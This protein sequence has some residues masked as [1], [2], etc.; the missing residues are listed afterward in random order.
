MK[1]SIRIGLAGAGTVGGGVIKI[2]AQ[3]MSF[4]RN[5]LQLPLELKKIATLEPSRLKNFPVGTAEIVGDG[6]EVASDPEI[7]I[8][9]ELIG[10]TTVAKEIVLTAIE[11]GKH[12]ITAN[13]KLIAECGPEIFSAADKKNVSVYF[14]AAV[15]GGMPTIKT[16]RESLIGNNTVSFYGIINGTCNYILTKMTEEG[17][18]F[19]E[20]LKNAQKLGYAEAD[21]TLDIDG[22]DTGHKI[23]IMASLLFDGFVDVNKM[24]IDGIRNITS[25]D[26]KFAKDLGYTIKLLGIAKKNAKDKSII[27]RVNPV[28][29]PQ[30][31]ILANVR[32]VF[33]AALFT[34][35]AVGDI[36]LY[37]KGAGE[38]PTAS[39]V[40]SD[41]VDVARNIVSG[42]TKRIPMRL[43]SRE[44]EIVLKTAAEIASR[45]YL[46]FTVK[47][48]PG[49]IGVIATTFG[50]NNISIASVDQ[51]ESHDD[52]FVPIIFTTDE[53][54]EA[55]VINSVREIEKNS[56][57][58]AATQYIRIE[59]K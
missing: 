47:D 23:A 59:E 31:H 28:M 22:G 36:M 53:A 56:F 52:D 1:N 45:F 8:V 7:D 32:D 35:D 5:K 17:S 9:I 12:V 51:S 33:N 27:V 11:N 48:Q 26:I 30:N 54:N 38:L 29:L 19:S 2:L 37:G 50:K 58:K 57:I 21:P 15:G 25:D 46:R 44:N 49:V 41:V 34:G 55:D 16:A 18:D 4:F 3:E 13:K 24:Q 6:L 40:I 42:D 43:Y 39:A 20:T 14:E 10:G